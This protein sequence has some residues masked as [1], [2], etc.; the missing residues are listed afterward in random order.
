M[1]KSESEQ[2][3][4]LDQLAEEFAARFRRGER[5]TIEEYA[6]NYPELADDIRE[7]FPAMVK[8][9]RVEG[10][11][12][13]EDESAKL[14]AAHPP[15]TQ[16]GDYRILRQIGRGGMGVVYEAEQI[17]LGRR[18]ALKVL[19][20]PMSVNPMIL[21]RFRREARAAA[22]LHHTN[23]VPVY[24]VGQDGDVRYYAMQF[25]QGQSLDA[26]IAELRRLRDRS[27]SE[28]P[29]RAA[30]DGPSPRPVAEHS[31]RGIDD[32]TLGE[33]VEVSAALRFL[34]TCRFDPGDRGPEPFGD[35]PSMRA[36]A[37]DGSTAGPAETEGATS[38][39]VD[40]LMPVHPFEPAP[41]SSAPPSPSSAILPGGTLLSSVESGH[42]VF[43]RS[44]AH[45]GR[46]VAG[47]LAYAHARG[48]VHRDIKPSNLLLDTEG[49]VWI[50]DFG[51][52]KGDDEGLTQ[53]GDILGTIRYM[54]PERF[55]GEGDARADV[56]AL[57][58]T[59]YELL[60][61]RSGFDTPDR[62]KLIEEIKTTEPT[63]PRS[64]DGR[65]PRDLETIVLK[66]I[67][68][69]PRARYP[70]AEAMGED[71]G[72]FLADQPIRARQIGASER[73]WRWA[74]RDQGI[75]AL[76]G[77]LIGVL[78]LA[79]AASMI[80]AGHMSL[81]A[82]QRGYAARAERSARE[83]ASR[84]ARAE[85]LARV[86]A[87]EARAAAEKDRAAALAQTYRATLSQVKS[88]RAGRQPGWR[89]E[90]LADLAR[91]AVM[92]TPRRD[93]PELRT[94][95]AATL[96]T[97]DIRLVARIELPR[98]NLRSIAFSPDGRTLVTAD[99][100][101]GLDFWDLP[102]Q[103]HLATVND[104]KVTDTECDQ[105]VY[106]PD[107]QGLAVAT[108]DRGVVFSDPQGLRTT[109]P[110][111][112]RGA[113]QPARLEIDGDG[114]RIAV[115]WMNGAG[116][117][118]HDLAGGALLDEFKDSPFALS[119]DG[120]RLA[121]LEDG[122][123][124]LHAIAKSEPRVVLGR[125]GPIRSLAFSGDGAMLAGASF[126]HTTMLWDVAKRENFGTLRG[127]RETVN[128][129]AFSPDGRWLATAS[130]DYT[131][132]IW[133]TRTGQ[134][135][136][137]L[138]GSAWIRQVVWSPDGTYLATTTHSHQTV[139]LYR[140]TGRDHVQQ[141]L[142]GH[143]N[144]LKSVAAHPR[145]EEFATYGVRELI[146]WDT[147]ARQPS[148]RRL[149]SEPSMG[150]AVAYSPDGSLLATASW[151]TS[152]VRRILIRDAGS[153]E[154]RRK[155]T[156][157]S[158][159]FALVFDPTGRRLASGDLDGNLIVWDLATGRPLQ[160]FDPG[161]ETH[162]IAFLDGG[163]SLA[164][165]GKGGILIYDLQSGEIARRAIIPGGVGKFATDPTRNRLVAAIPGGAIVSITL[166]GLTP[167][168]RLDNAHKGHIEA[169]ALS[170]DGRLLATGAED[171]RLV[172]RRSDDVRAPAEP[173]GL[174]R[175]YKGHGDRLRESTAGH[176]RQRFRRGPLG[177]RRAPRRP[178]GPRPGLGPP[179]P[180]VG[181]R[182]RPLREPRLVDAPGRRHPARSGG[183][184]RSPRPRPPGIGKDRLR[185]CEE[186]D[187]R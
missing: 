34:L 149:G 12:Q 94:E 171:H 115:S 91:L 13:D 141:W 87:D 89:D 59:L 176:R 29:T 180:T 63:K 3:D 179:R 5:P 45:I 75:A 6:D 117:T 27:R 21:E 4:R 7:L 33:A 155:I 11:R 143:G 137:T 41:S 61:L 58:L 73:F 82:E 146:T 177:P 128:D 142:T 23:I 118:L 48:I 35:P 26:V 187:S 173:P 83:D 28:A 186:F 111:I 60:A 135:I 46:Q 71:L 113:S 166:P 74:R 95:A 96:A 144:E 133:E 182:G 55:R 24:E 92:P 127:H 97:P 132:R 19:P 174:V 109:R 114:R 2:Y 90:A 20:G 131:A 160:R 86:D 1:S 36:D 120:R 76:G 148:P 156:G 163:R 79:T 122:M 84:Q 81:L 103:R 66:A 158:V 136:A 30:L 184:G 145:R 164:A 78:I 51:L 10:A 16:V 43:F 22:R 162:A 8:V 119:P 126:D 102:G 18:V 52:A 53:S 116:I 32:L 68:K 31:H 65:I 98:H 130:G 147:S 157:P 49:V 42:R 106:L 154:I 152:G 88:L 14:Q 168:H 165:N 100:D 37:L 64:V 72:R 107:G 17:S 101:R 85:S 183:I 134:I 9:E 44:V 167:G 129:A 108:R 62:L 38:A 67:E 150:T 80:V 57:G 56:Y 125:A 139:F 39:K 104:L 175:E 138:P 47:G 121:R 170:P 110:S 112:T 93:L 153:G 25:I 69:D 181:S 124:V 105:V 161:S 169:L 54:A 50:A 123:V 140:I 151:T 70:S 172:L 159:P 185:G 178:V 99:Y 77:T 15:L 40:G